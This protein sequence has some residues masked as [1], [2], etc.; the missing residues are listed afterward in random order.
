MS[1]GRWVLVAAVITGVALAGCGSSG[2]GSGTGTSTT[3]AGTQAKANTAS[4]S[5][6]QETDAVLTTGAEE[7]QSDFS[8]SSEFSDY[9]SEAADYSTTAYDLQAYD[10]PSGYESDVL[11]LEGDLQHESADAAQIAADAKEAKPT[12][13]ALAQ[14]QTDEA[15]ASTDGASVRHDLGIAAKAPTTSTTGAG[16]SSS[17][18]STSS[19]SSTSSSQKGATTSSTPAVSSP[20]EPANA[21]ST[22]TIAISP[23]TVLEEQGS[24]NT[25]TQQFTVPS[26][27]TGWTLKWMYNCTLLG[28]SG[29]FIVDV[30]GHGTSKQTRDRGPNELG[31]GGQ[32]TQHYFDTGTFTL[33]IASECEWSV[34]ATAV[35]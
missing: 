1:R 9:A 7:I 6:A 17:S 19:T 28:A 26:S 18:T 14:L 23:P 27:S 2:N 35:S 31:E 3:K 22:T 34:L 32:G 33:E 15:A 29:N 30:V 10:Y 24:G 4:K 12:E 13:S 8:G 21:G 11:A 16:S 25:T 5:L 20:A